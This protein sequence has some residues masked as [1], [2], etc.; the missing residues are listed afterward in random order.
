MSW[1]IVRLSDGKGVYETW[2]ASI[3]EKVNTEKYKVLTAL[4]YLCGLNEPDLFN[5]RAVK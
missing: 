5:H 4:D 2:N 3:L 1:I